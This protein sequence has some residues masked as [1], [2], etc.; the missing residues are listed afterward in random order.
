MLAAHC[1]LNSALWEAVHEVQPN[2]LLLLYDSGVFQSLGRG[3]HQPC[4]RTS[5]PIKHPCLACLRYL[6]EYHSIPHVVDRLYYRGLEILLRRLLTIGYS[7]L[8]REVCGFVRH[9]H[10]LNGSLPR[11]FLSLG[12][13][14]SFVPLLLPFQSWFIYHSR[15]LT[16]CDGESRDVKRGCRP[17][18]PKWAIARVSTHTPV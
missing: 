8:R 11:L 6:Q 7:D 18:P 16:Y 4:L 15:S 17:P 2:V 5:T 3:G 1:D 12:F 13:F 10:I 14:L 9:D